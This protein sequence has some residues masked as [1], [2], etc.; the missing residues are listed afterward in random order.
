MNHSRHGASLTP[1]RAGSSCHPY[2]AAKIT[3]GTVTR[4]VSAAGSTVRTNG[5]MTSAARK[6]STTLGRL[7]ISST[8]GLTR[9]RM[10]GDRNSLV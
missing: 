2:A 7:A 6:P 9:D 5:A 8:A 4:A 10:R 1:A 3:P